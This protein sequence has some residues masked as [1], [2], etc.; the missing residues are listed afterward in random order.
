MFI[1]IFQNFRL[2]LKQLARRVLQPSQGYQ[3]PVLLMLTLLHYVR[4]TSIK[5]E[6][7]K[8]AGTLTEVDSFN[9][10]E[11]KDRI[12]WCHFVLSLFIASPSAARKKIGKAQEIQ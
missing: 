7:Q 1:T 9:S 6:K 10:T 12:E 2:C 4:A 8:P 11:W 5:R 3:L